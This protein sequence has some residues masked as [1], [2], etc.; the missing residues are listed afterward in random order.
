MWLIIKYLVTVVLSVVWLLEM[1][2]P[3]QHLRL[4]NHVD[5]VKIEVGFTKIFCNYNMELD[6]DD[7][8]DPVR[9]MGLSRIAASGGGPILSMTAT[10]TADKV[11]VATPEPRWRYVLQ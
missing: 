5:H 11:L 1:V 4:K 3:V 7:T 9:R 2:L 8:T 6:D 10:S